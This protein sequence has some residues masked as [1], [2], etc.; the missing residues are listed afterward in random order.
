MRKIGGINGKAA[1]KLF[2]DYLTSEKIENK[3][4][5]AD[6]DQWSVWVFRDEQLDEARRFLEEYRANGKDPK[7]FKGQQK[8]SALITQ[9]KEAEQRVAKMQKETLAKMESRPS[10]FGWMTGLVLFLCL[11]VAIWGGMTFDGFSDMEAIAPLLISENASGPTFVE[12][13]QGQVWRLISPVFIHFGYLHLGFNLMVFFYFGRMIET[14][15]G[16]LLF[17]SLFLV[18]GVLSNVAQYMVSHA[19]FGGLSGV[20][21]ALFGYVWMKSRFDPFSGYFLSD[22]NVV[23]FMVWLVICFFGLMGDVANFAHLGGLITGVVW[24]FLAARFFR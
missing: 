6:E 21:Y 7:F 3:I 2:G 20:D 16:L 5:A 23:F 11:G 24:G 9:Q 22:Q 19:L 18:S 8:V 13:S 4:D 1:A 15:G 17:V 14:R 12:V 10:H